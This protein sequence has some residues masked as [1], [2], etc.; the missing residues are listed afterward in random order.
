MIRKAFIMSV[1]P[2]CEAE[3]QQRHQPIW[4][5]LEKVLRTHGVHQYS[6]FFDAPSRQLFAYA[7]IANEAQWAAIATTDVCQRWWKSMR[8]LMPTN[9]DHSPIAVSLNEVFHLE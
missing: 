1:N 9:I 8:H 6:I 3:Y 4:P 5:E 7:E 2:G